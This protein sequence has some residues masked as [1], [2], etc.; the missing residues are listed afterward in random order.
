MLQL[1]SPDHDPALFPGA[2]L[3]FDELKDRPHVVAN[4]ALV[5]AW[6]KAFGGQ[7]HRALNGFKLHS[8]TRSGSSPDDQNM[9][10]LRGDRG[11]GVRKH[12]A[13]VA[14][15]SPPRKEG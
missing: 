10:V 12:F 1:S 15:A 5:G 6:A 7:A 13:S 11:E 4:V 14:A 3:R 9:I 2:H 8:D